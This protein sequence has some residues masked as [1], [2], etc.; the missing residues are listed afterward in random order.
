MIRID[1]KRCTGCGACVR[2]CISGVFVMKGKAPEAVFPQL[3]NRC[4]HCIAVCPAQAIVHEGLGST[5]PG[6]IQKRLVQARSYREIALSR[7]SVR[8]YTQEPVPREIVEEILD[9]ARYSPTASNSQNV[10]YTVVADRALLEKV[11]RRLFRIGERINRVFTLGPVQA[12]SARFKDVGPVKILE[13]YSRRWVFYREQ[14]AA[15]KD[16]IFHNAPMLLLLHTSGGQGLSRD[17]C[18]IA[19]TN[20]ANYAHCLGLGTCFIGILTTAMRLDRSLYGL[21]KIPRR[22]TVHAALT[23]GY[24]AVRYVRHVVRKPAAVEW[25]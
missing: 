14:V 7:R 2:D 21:F 5:V 10:H 6:R 3:C 19:A 8:Q 13:R 25:V 24:P 23:L 12:A 22:H 20:I 1:P 16:L 15:G 11:S 17:N 9:L 18:L 4:S